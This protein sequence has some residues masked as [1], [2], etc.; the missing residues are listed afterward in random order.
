[1]GHLTR[2]CMGP[3]GFGRLLIAACLL[4]VGGA[5]T[6]PGAAASAPW[7]T[8]GPD[9]VPSHGALLG[10]WSLPRSGRTDAQELAYVESEI[11]EPFAIY[12]TY[13]QATTPMPTPDMRSA[14]ASGHID[15]VDITPG[16]SWAE[17]A[18]GATDSQLIAQADGLRAFGY[19]VMVTFDHEANARIG[20]SGTPAQFV[21]AWRHVY[22]VY[23]RQGATNV[24]WVWDMTG[25]LFDNEQNANAMYPGGGYVDWVAADAYNWSP[26][27]AGAPWRTFQQAFQPFYTWTLHTGKPAMAEETGVVENP[28]DPG[29]KAQWYAGMA[30]SVEAWPNMKAVVYFNSSRDGAWW[31]DSTAQALA[32]FRAVAQSPYFNPETQQPPV[33]TVAPAITG[34]A[35]VGQ[36]LRVTQGTW[37]GA[38]TIGDQ[39]VDCAAAGPCTPIPGATGSGYTVAESDAGYAIG[40]LETAT[41]AAGSAVATAAPSSPVSVAGPVT[42]T[43]VPVVTTA[44]IAF[45]LY[46]PATVTVE[47][48]D[49]SGSVVRHKVNARPYAAGS[50]S[51]NWSRMTDAGTRA[52]PGVYQAVVIAAAPDG[53]TWRQSVPFTVGTSSTG[54]AS[55]RR[56]ASP[57]GWST[58]ATSGRS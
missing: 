3:R 32:A 15:L 27:R 2:P 51:A 11:G 48:A 36:T 42:V 23:R 30:A 50:V 53:A 38:T 20:S 10:T 52:R 54:A 43:P 35:Q 44:T 26:V 39:W 34:T 41:D 9:L 37:T 21:A 31:F 17:V 49:A 4:F 58:V 57:D 24:I 28:S 19:P 8:L 47:I 18:A 45:T 40:L 29:A 7:A 56:Y 6:S 14:A 55:M 13:A 1:M 33:D 22:D 25:E 46:R 5:H 16:A 12:H